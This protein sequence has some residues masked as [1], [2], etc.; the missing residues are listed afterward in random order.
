MT[1]ELH[2]IETTGKIIDARHIETEALL[3]VGRQVRVLVL[4]PEASADDIPEREWLI[5]ASNNPAFAFLGDAAEDLYSLED[6][7]P[8]VHP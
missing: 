7:E 2:A 6:G 3:P 8:F 1:H 5:A 4:L